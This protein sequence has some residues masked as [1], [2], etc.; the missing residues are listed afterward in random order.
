MV[1][2]LPLVM[3]IYLKP[4]KKGHKTV[5]EIY[6]VVHFLVVTR[7]RTLGLLNSLKT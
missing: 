6:M 7:G 5:Q 2:Y 3:R 4:H 1:L